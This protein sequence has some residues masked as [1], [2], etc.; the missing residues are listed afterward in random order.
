MEGGRHRQV[1]KAF[2]WNVV[3]VKC[4]T[5]T[6]LC[7][8]TQCAISFQKLLWS[9]FGGARHQLTPAPTIWICFKRDHLCFLK[10]NVVQRC[11]MNSS[12]PDCL[13]KLITYSTFRICFWNTGHAWSVSSHLCVI[14]TLSCRSWPAASLMEIM[15]CFMCFKFYCRFPF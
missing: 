3:I 12:T 13:V 8:Y 7:S 9:R 5:H 6:N 15:T 4:T 14:A 1:K 2:R 10:H 11:K